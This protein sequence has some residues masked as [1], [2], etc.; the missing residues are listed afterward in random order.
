MELLYA[1]QARSD[2]PV[3]RDVRM[4]VE[5]VATQPKLTDL[6]PS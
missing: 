1:R 6:S 3:L 2:L 5:K 4:D